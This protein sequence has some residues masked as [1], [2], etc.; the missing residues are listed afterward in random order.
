MVGY[1]YNIGGQEGYLAIPGSRVFV[2]IKEDVSSLSEINI[3]RQ[4]EFS[5]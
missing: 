2:V 5:G 4:K 1:H 3:M